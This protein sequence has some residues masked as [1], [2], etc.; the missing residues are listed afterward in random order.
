M[1]AIFWP[2]NP[3]P[4]KVDEYKIMDCLHEALGSIH[5][6]HAYDLA[7][8]MISEAAHQ[9]WTE[10]MHTQQVNKVEPPFKQHRHP[11]T[12]D[13]KNARHQVLTDGRRHKDCEGRASAIPDSP[14]G[15][16]GPLQCQGQITLEKPSRMVNAIPAGM[17]GN[18]HQQ[19]NLLNQMQRQNQ[20]LEQ[21]E[22]PMEP[23]P[24]V[25]QMGK[26]L[27]KGMERTGTKVQT[28]PIPSG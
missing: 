18:H 27:L 7:C 15:R 10:E 11:H 9:R 1:P 24:Q 26:I 25:N 21:P 23:P 14:K 6:T 20:P 5:I 28:P 22:E 13:T 16:G 8:E 3:F 2:V 17:E 12:V 19:I 4:H